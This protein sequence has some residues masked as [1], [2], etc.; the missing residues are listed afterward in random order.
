MGTSHRYRTAW[1]RLHR[2]SG[3]GVHSPFAYKF[4]TCVLRARLPY[5]A[6]AEL[7]I[8]RRGVIA[9]TSHLW[10]HPRIISYTNAAPHLATG[11][12]LRRVER[13]HAVG[14]APEPPH[15]L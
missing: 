5:Y 4:I 6:Y 14:V 7:R 1:S 12:E 8:L 2:S 13:V 11:H 15:P 3:F 9:A 10:R